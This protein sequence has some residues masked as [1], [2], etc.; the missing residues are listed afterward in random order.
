MELPSGLNAAYLARSVLSCPLHPEK[1]RETLTMA[2]EI[3]LSIGN[4]VQNVKGLRD[5]RFGVVEQLLFSQF[6]TKCGNYSNV[7]PLPAVTQLL[8]SEK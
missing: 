8:H 7:T 4:L 6:T 5:H 2:T 1:V 3:N